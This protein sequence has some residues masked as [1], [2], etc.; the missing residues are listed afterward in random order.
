[1]GGEMH[2]IYDGGREWRGRTRESRG[3]GVGRKESE[4]KKGYEEAVCTCKGSEWKYP[5]GEYSRQALEGQRVKQQ[6]NQTQRFPADRPLH[7]LHT[8]TKGN[9]TSQMYMDST[10]NNYR[11]MPMKRRVPMEKIRDGSGERMGYRENSEDVSRY[12]GGWNCVDDV[13]AG[14]AGNRGGRDINIDNGGVFY[15]ADSSKY[16]IYRAPVPP[17]NWEYSQQLTDCPPPYMEGSRRGLGTYILGGVPGGIPGGQPGG[18][19]LNMNNMKYMKYMSNMSHMN[20]MSNMNNMNHMNNMSNNINS[21]NNNMNMNNYN[22]NNNNNMNT[23]NNS[24]NV[25]NKPPPY[26]PPQLPQPPY[27]PPQPPQPPYHPPQPPQPPYQP[28]YQPPQPPIKKK[29]RKETT[30]YY[31]SNNINPPNSGMGLPS[32]L[33]NPSGH[34]TLD[35]NSPLD[36]NQIS[37]SFLAPPSEN[38]LPNSF[39]YAPVSSLSPHNPS[40]NIFDIPPQNNNHKTN[41]NNNNNNN[42]NYPQEEDGK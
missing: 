12:R 15:V 41:N 7:H 11:G 35:F 39:Y 30:G 2:L 34:F 16:D 4:E 23:N 9:S 20:N 32:G 6:H 37:H 14:R 28:P 18:Q 22:N 10:A 17:Y 24:N 21:N 3:I 5:Y 19:P 26:H 29:E 36:N 31:P 13:E 27:H 40:K 1:M 8:P 33:H 25:I 42:N 38:F